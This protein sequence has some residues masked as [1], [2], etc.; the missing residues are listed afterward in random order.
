MINS[1]FNA[2]QKLQ[3]LMILHLHI[4]LYIIASYSF[5]NIS[6][7]YVYKNKFDTKVIYGHCASSSF[8]RFN[9]Q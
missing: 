7:V 4:L 2:C 3:K 6:T 8:K 9:R 1:P 5:D